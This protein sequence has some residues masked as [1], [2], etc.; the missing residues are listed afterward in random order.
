MTHTNP[1]VMAQEQDT[2][3]EKLAEVNTAVDHFIK[4]AAQ[5]AGNDLSAQQIDELGSIRNEAEKQLYQLLHAVKGPVQSVYSHAEQV[6]IEE[7]LKSRDILMKR[8][9]CTYRSRSCAPRD[10]SLPYSA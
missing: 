9:E 4:I 2:I 7:S 10:G 3:K 8:T 5:N 1:K 6:G